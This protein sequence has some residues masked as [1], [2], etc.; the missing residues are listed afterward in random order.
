[1]SRL[2]SPIKGLVSKFHRSPSPRPPAKPATGTQQSP[3]IS[4]LTAMPMQSGNLA[5]EN[6]YL[7]IGGPLAV[8]VDP[9]TKVQQAKAVGSAV[10]EGLK[11]VVKGLYNCSDMFLPL[12]AAAGGILTFIEL[13][14]VSGSMYSNTN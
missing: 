2:L 6:G 5:Q 12:K 13:V 10:Y 14:E 11:I 7:A 1:M 3:P 4:A 9:E 8:V